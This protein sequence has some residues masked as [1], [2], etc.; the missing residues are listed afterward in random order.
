M[1]N[2]YLVK[3]V[4]E[5]NAP[6]P[7]LEA[8]REEFTK[9]IIITVCGNEFVL[10]RRFGWFES[11]VEI[12][13]G[14][15]KVYLNLDRNSK[16]NAKRASARFE[17]IMQNIKDLDVKFKDFCTD[18]M[19]ENAN[20]W[21]EDENDPNITADEFKENMGTPNELVVENSGKVEIFYGDG[22]KFGGHAIQVS[23]NA[24]NEIKD[25]ELVG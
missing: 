24:D 2:R 23:V 6:S 20:E 17:E 1:N 9:D 18:R 19:L 11:N 13:G 22:Y 21:K 3:K 4:M 14:T 8:F 12:L 5:E 7:E 15:C 25:C 10:N 16:K